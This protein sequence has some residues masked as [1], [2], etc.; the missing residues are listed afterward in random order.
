MTP[1]S[2]SS[3]SGLPVRWSVINTSSFDSKKLSQENYA[4]GRTNVL[5]AGWW[6]R[7]T[8]DAAPI[9]LC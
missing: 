5:R 9:Q 4:M 8:A 2:V 3:A 6:W 1:R 7:L